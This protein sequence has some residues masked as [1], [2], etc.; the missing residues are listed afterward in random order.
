MPELRI[1]G[2]LLRSVDVWN[3]AQPAQSR[4]E[5]D[6][7]LLYLAPEEAQDAGIGLSTP[8]ECLVELNGEHEVVATVRTWHAAG[9]SGSIACVLVA[10]PP[11]LTKLRRAYGLEPARRA[12]SIA[13]SQ[14]ASNELTI[15][16]FGT[17]KFLRCF[18]D[19]FVH[20][21]N[22]MD[23][24]AGRVVVIQ[25]T[26]TARATAL[27][28]Q[29]RRYRVA[30]RG[31]EGGKRV[32]RT[33]EVRSVGLALAAA[34]DWD[35][36]L[37]LAESPTLRTVISNTTE[38]GYSLHPDDHPD[39]RPPRSFPAKL[40]AVL[41]DRFRAGLP[42]LTILPCELLE[43][44]GTR[45]VGLL[46]EQSER[47]GLSSDFGQWVRAGCFRS[48]TLVDR[49]VA[50]PAP[51]DPLAEDDALFAVAEPYAL[52]LLDRPAAAGPFSPHPAVRVVRD[53][54]PFHLRKVRILN[55]AH[56]ALVAKARPLGLATV[57]QAVEDEQVRPWLESLLF[58]EIVP[59]LEGRT[60]EPE[61]FARDVLERFANPFLEHRLDDI[62]LHHDVKLQT[63]LVPT[64][65]EYRERFSRAPKRLEEILP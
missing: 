24:P 31:L 4:E 42:P 12:T 64:L 14:P 20:E 36:V 50:A 48:N 41:R 21:L 13:A 58:E 59:T 53:L 3:T 26:G 52:W 18:A 34:T 9:K 51:D 61:Q 60:E 15:L 6:R 44:N 57:R 19:L 29:R 7:A 46:L 62:A 38:A 37:E 39:D 5:A 16:Q 43:E 40:L 10:P 32:D 45:L 8:Q 54:Q 25:S 11:F 56:T 33:V 30:I 35:R 47:W 63:R 17:G 65:Q 49:I 55:G 27:N 23:R 28:D 22:E 1:N 2:S